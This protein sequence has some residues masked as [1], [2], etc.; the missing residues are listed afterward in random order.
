MKFALDYNACFTLCLAGLVHFGLW[1]KNSGD[2]LNFDRSYPP[3]DPTLDI[4]ISMDNSEYLLLLDY[5]NYIIC[6]A[7]YSH[8]LDSEGTP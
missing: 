1:V 4:T 2:I 3:K 5:P 7:R 6:N 8:Y